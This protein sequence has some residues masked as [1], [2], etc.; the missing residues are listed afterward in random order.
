M[1]VTLDTNVIPAEKFL[2]ASNGYEWDFVVVSVTTREFEGTDFL[3]KLKPIGKIIETGV[4]GESKYGRAKY[5]SEKTQADRED[6]LKIISFGS[7]PKDR[8]NLSEGQHR[9]LRDAMIFQAHVRGRRD[10]F[11]TNDRRGFIND[12]RREKLQKLFNTQIMTPNEFI[13]F[14]NEKRKSIPADV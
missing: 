6:I 9:Q 11:V 4:Y 10:I 14:C 1:K 2:T 7:F 12:G 5:G 8:Q 13:G 3:V